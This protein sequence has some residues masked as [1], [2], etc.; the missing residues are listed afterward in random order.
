MAHFE[1]MQSAIDRKRE[2]IAKLV[3]RG[4]HSRKETT[5]LMVESVDEPSRRYSPPVTRDCEFP[6]VLSSDLVGGLSTN[7]I[8]AKYCGAQWQGSSFYR[9]VH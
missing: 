9:K 6:Q 1:L 2:T 8:L 3:S 4:A 5:L 7:A